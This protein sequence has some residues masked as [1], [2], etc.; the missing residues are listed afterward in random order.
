[1][2]ARAFAVPGNRPDDLATASAALAWGIMED[3]VIAEGVRFAAALDLAHEA[4][5][6]VRSGG[7]HARAALQ[8]AISSVLDQVSEDDIRGWFRPLR[9]LQLRKLTG[10]RSKAGPESR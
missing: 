8:A 6:A 3:A 4:R 2:A 10:N 9:V 5:I 1:L 7:L